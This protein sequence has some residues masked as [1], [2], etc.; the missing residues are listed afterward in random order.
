MD[1]SYRAEDLV[2]RDELRTYLRDATPPEL[3]YKVENGIEMKRDDVMGWHRILYEK[4]WV[5]P[6]WPKEFGGPGWT[7]TQKYIFDEEL[8]LAGAPRLVTFSLN[9]CGPVLIGF[10][11]EEQKA[12]FLPPMLAG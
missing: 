2:F 7:L 1:L 12:R 9:M 5:A 8:G 3:K 4:G 6:N 11:T 10:G